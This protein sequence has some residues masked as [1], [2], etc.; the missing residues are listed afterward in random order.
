MSAEHLPEPLVIARDGLKW[1][2]VGL[3]S[4]T[5]LG[6]CRVFK[7]SFCESWKTIRLSR[8]ADAGR[9]V[10]TLE[11]SPQPMPSFPIKFKGVRFG[12]ISF[13]G[14][15]DTLLRCPHC[16]NLGKISRFL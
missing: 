8:S 7:A 1:R 15:P 9:S 4:L 12:R 14:L 6:T 10:S 3:C 11:S 2:M 13:S 5:K 16:E